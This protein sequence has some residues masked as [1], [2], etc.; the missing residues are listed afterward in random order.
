MLT[1]SHGVRHLLD[2]LFTCTWI[3]S[4]TTTLL[5][6]SCYNSMYVAEDEI[7]SRRGSVDELDPTVLTVTSWE[8]TGK[9]EI[10]W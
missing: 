4:Y 2:T 6:S 5:E 1:S 3:I 7:A 10:S 8:N 9:M